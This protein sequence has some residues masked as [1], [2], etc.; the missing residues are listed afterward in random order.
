MKPGFKF[1]L[2]TDGKC[3]VLEGQ[4]ALL[5]SLYLLLGPGRQYHPGEPSFGLRRKRRDLHNICPVSSPL[6]KADHTIPCSIISSLCHPAST[7]EITIPSSLC[8]RLASFQ[9]RGTRTPRMFS[10]PGREPA[11]CLLRLIPPGVPVLF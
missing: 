10:V 5:S 1:P 3:T 4:D 2:P 6:L 8:R 9:R 7:A 11:V